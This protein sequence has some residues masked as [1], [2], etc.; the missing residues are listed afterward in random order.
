MSVLSLPLTVRALR[1]EVAAILE[2]AGIE[3]PHNEARDLIAAVMDQPRFWPA[4]NA[5]DVIEGER[6]RRAAARRARGMPFA[7]A[8]GKAP[9]RHLTLVV[10]ERVLIPRQET[11]VLID[12]VLQATGG[13]GV[14]ADVGTGSGCIALALATEGAF[15]RVIATDVSLPAIDLARLNT[16]T[17]RPLRAAIEIRE[18]DLLAPLNAADGLTAI[19]SNP[20]YIAHAEMHELPPSVR[21]WEPHLALASHD[22]G[23]AH[24]RGIVDAAPDVLLSGGILAL[25]VDSRRARRVAQYVSANSA[26]ADSKVHKDLTGRVRFVLATRR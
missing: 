8:V 10:D 6:V 9:F 17:I 25:E 15:G 23:M 4:Q 26:Y 1:S 7:Y 13:K 21:D 24:I 12:L 2:R 14:V 20:P 22:D 16:Q 18:G 5:D 19:V 11:E 3:Q